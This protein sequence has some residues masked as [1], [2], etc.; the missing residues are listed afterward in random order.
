MGW[1]R[2]NSCVL[3]LPSIAFQTN[4]DA[5]LEDAEQPGV[6]EDVQEVLLR[7]DDAYQYQNIFGPLV[8][9]EADYD[10]RLKETLV[11]GE[12]VCV[13][14]LEFSWCIPSPPTPQTDNVT[15]RWDRALNRKFVAYFVFPRQDLHIT[16]GDN[17]KLRY[18]GS[19]HS[20]WETKGIVSK[21]SCD[22]KNQYQI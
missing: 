10:K 1:G 19:L 9:L 17:L 15:V 7:Y 16:I 22:E 8:K 6:D 11:R 20:P 3:I 14:S 4:P 5:T 2:V 12:S 13:W 18:T 21:V